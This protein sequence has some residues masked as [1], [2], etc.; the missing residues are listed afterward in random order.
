MSVIYKIKTVFWRF[1]T[2]IW[3][4]LPVDGK[5]IVCS[6]FLGKG[7]GDN[8]KYI[9]EEII[10]QGLDYHLVWLQGKEDKDKLPKGIKKVRYGSIWAL[11]ELYTA[12]VIINNV[13]NGP[14]WEKKPGQYY[15]NTCHGGFP[16]KYIEKEVEEK[17]STSYVTASKMDSAITDV[18]LSGSSL[19]SDVIRSSFW[20][21][22]EIMESGQPRCDMLFNVSEEK[23]ARLKE[24]LG[25]SRSTSVVLYAPTFRDS[26]EVKPYGLDIESFL[27]ALQKKYSR[28][29]VC[30][31][32]LH[33]NVADEDVGFRYGDKLIDGSK[34]PDPQDLIVLS[35]L[36]IT[37]YSTIMIDFAIMRKP[38][39]L[40]VPDHDEYRNRDRGLRP[41]YDILPFVKCRTDK[42][43]TEAVASFDEVEYQKKLDAFFR[44]DY[45]CFEDGHASERVVERIKKLV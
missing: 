16:L 3:K 20:Y 19:H 23:K 40:Y 10:R 12:K 13:K 14:Y 32:R 37:D 39:L 22:G 4:I 38:I 25:I 29:W 11:Y 15:I 30:I 27:A 6:N 43:L 8:P 9:C 26:G 21:S 41:I 2:A 7:Y 33:P 18:I 5:K 34:Y 31:V 45:I 28:E 35:D 1:L 24:S 42:E 36:M 44:D 17:L